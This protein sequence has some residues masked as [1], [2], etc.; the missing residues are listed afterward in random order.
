MLWTLGFSGAVSLLA[1]AAF[2]Y[3]GSRFVGRGAG[4]DHAASSAFAAW[5]FGIGAYTGIQGAED[6]LGAVGAAPVPL[7]VA[8]RF[9]TLPLICGAFAGLAHYVLH[10]RTGDPRWAPRVWTY[11]GLLAVALVALVALGRPDAVV[12][13]RWRT[14]VSYSAALRGPILLVVLLLI[15][16]PEV[17]AS[18]AYL[19]LYRRAADP[20]Q[21]RRVLVVGSSLL[22]WLVA[23]AVSRASE[24]DALQLVARPT[25]GAGVAIAVA[26]AYR[27]PRAAP[28]PDARAMALQRR[29]RD[30]V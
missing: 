10:V 28:G 14:D 25:L 27:H 1:A 7:F 6:V 18:W 8:L 12:I 22:L 4:A 5:W 16:L 19:A 20:V 11:Y 23:T 26:L 15:V 24:S 2:A 30:L 3:A 29:I 17:A 13:Q 9:A 21:R